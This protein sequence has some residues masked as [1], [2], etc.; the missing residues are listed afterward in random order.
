MYLLLISC[1]FLGI[2]QTFLRQKVT[3][4]SSNPTNEGAQEST[5]KAKSLEKENSKHGNKKECEG[6]E[7]FDESGKSCCLKSYNGGSGALRYA[8]HLRFVCPLP[9]KASKKPGE[10]ETTGQEKN[11]DSDGKRRFY[12]YNDLRVVFPQRHTDSDEGKVRLRDLRFESSC[13]A[14]CKHRF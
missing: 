2:I 8:L 12:L 13:P 7:K 3:L 6:D 10:T 9:K 14:C 4:G 1:L 5:R 11:L